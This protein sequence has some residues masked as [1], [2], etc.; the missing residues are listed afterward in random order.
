MIDMKSIKN[1]DLE[2]P[3]SNAKLVGHLMSADFFDSEKISG[4][5]IC[6]PQTLKKGTLNHILLPEI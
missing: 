6:N 1:I 2:D 5:G 3:E 4:I